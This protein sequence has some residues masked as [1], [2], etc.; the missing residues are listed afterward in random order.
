VSADMYTASMDD[1]DPL[2]EA[3]LPPDKVAQLAQGVA[4]GKSDSVQL[5]LA[6]LLRKVSKGELDYVEQD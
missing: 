6:E 1:E 3:V 5:L 2:Q 4:A